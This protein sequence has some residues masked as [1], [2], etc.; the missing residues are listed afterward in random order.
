MQHF[1]FSGLRFSAKVPLRNGCNML[2]NLG[3]STKRDSA[4][5][6]GLESRG[7]QRSCGPLSDGGPRRGITPRKVVELSKSNGAL[8]AVRT[9][10]ALTGVGRTAGA[11]AQPEGVTQF[12]GG[13]NAM[14]AAAQIPQPV[15]AFDHQGQCDQQPYD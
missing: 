9:A 14:V 3:S 13:A 1:T 6:S 7:R 4:Q 11:Q 2:S 10:P 5:W 8:P 12:D 15:K